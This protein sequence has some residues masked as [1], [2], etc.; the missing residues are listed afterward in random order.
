MNRVVL[1]WKNEGKLSSN[2]W[3]WFYCQLLLTPYVKTRSSVG[4]NI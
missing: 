1:C 4:K 2:I 3:F